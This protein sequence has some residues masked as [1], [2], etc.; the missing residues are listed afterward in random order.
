MYVKTF[1]DGP[2]QANSYLVVCEK[3]NKAALIDANGFS[4]RAI[5]NYIKQNDIKLESLLLTHGHYDHVYGAKTVQETAKVPVYLNNKDLFLLE[6]LNEQLTISGLPPIGPPAEKPAKTTNLN[7]GDAVEVGDLKL[8]AILTPGH[9][10]GSLCFYIKEERKLFCGDL[11]L[12]NGVGRTDLPGGSY[13]VLLDSIHEIIKKLPP[14]VE[15]YPGHGP[16]STIKEECAINSFFIN[17]KEEL[18]NL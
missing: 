18:R 15:I 14:E 6:M 12:F 8:K 2:I 11:I 10:A 3:T 7:D 16:V 17:T 5:F 9:S 13:E 1:C 4:E